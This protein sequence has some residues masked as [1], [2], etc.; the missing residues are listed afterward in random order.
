MIGGYIHPGN[1]V[2]NMYFTLY[3][4]NSVQQAFAMLQDLKQGQYVKLSPRSTFA[5]QILGSIIGSIFNYIMMENIVDNQA[6]ILRSIEGTAIWSGQNVQQYNTQGITWGALAKHM[7]S[8]GS[9][10]EWVNFS[11]ALGFALPLPFYFG[12]KLFPKLGLRNINVPILV[13]YIGWLCV[14]VNSSITSY[15]IVAFGSQ[16][17]L[18]VYHPNLFKK[19]NYILAA[20][21]T[22]GAQVMV[23]IL[24]FAVAGASGA[25]HNFPSWWGNHL[26]T[27]TASYNFDRC[28][29]N[30]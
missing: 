30:D 1:P 26:S 3:G 5:A 12:D 2:A 15:F 25:G 29:F 28:Y 13:W 22:G 10:Y 17:Y 14:G 27:D 9:R 11:L 8:A 21:L 4:Y 6:D 23:F 16:W 18:R 19:Y 7:Y 24:S 20:G